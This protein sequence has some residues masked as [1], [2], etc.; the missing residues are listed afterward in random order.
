MQVKKRVSVQGT[1]AK[2]KEDIKDGDIIKILDEG[3]VV[4]GEFGDR[5]VF[6]VETKNGEKL[7]SFNQ[8][9]MNNLIDAFGQETSSWKDEQVKVWI[10]KSN[11]AGKMRDVVYLAFPDWEMGEDGL[12]NPDGE[13]PVVEE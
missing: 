3:K 2:I 11:V 6:K 7:L 10:I 4:A 8:T 1:W 5:N 12:Y 9:T 13:V